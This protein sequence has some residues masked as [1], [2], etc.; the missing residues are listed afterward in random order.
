MEP[1]HTRLS[2]FTAYY[3]CRNVEMYLKST[4]TSGFNIHEYNKFINV[5]LGVMLG[6]CIILDLS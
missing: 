2:I 4:T 3:T 1:S 6:D 5:I